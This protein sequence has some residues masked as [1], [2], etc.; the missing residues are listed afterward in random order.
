MLTLFFLWQV[1]SRRSGKDKGKQDELW[2]EVVK[3]GNGGKWEQAQ[4]DVTRI[5]SLFL[6]ADS[7]R[8]RR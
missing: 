1:A 8:S 4:E 5:H 6:L 3:E 2:W 7:Q